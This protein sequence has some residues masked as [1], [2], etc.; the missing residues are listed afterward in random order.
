M[1]LIKRAVATD[2][3]NESTSVSSCRPGSKLIHLSHRL[4]RL[5]G[6]PNPSL[7]I[8]SSREQPVSIEFTMLEFSAHFRCVSVVSLLPKPLP[9]ITQPSDFFPY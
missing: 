5:F 3:F 4:E 9:I 1:A 6:T 2:T 7:P 8:R